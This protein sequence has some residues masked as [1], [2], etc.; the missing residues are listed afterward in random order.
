M[1][2]A[3]STTQTDVDAV[4]EAG[5]GEEALYHLVATTGLSN[6]M[7]RLV[8]GLGIELHPAYV[9]TASERLAG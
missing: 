1:L 3:A 2:D 7:N 5:W 6:Y 9:T 4:L 8:E